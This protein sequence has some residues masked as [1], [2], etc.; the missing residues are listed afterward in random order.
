MQEAQNNTVELSNIEG[1]VLRLLISAIYGI[2]A[3]VPS[4]LLVPLFEAA[5]AHQVCTVLLAMSEG[6][7]HLPRQVQFEVLLP[8]SPQY[9]SPAT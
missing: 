8:T 3:P 9:V 1:P 4:E 5:D 6:G 7:P 2:H